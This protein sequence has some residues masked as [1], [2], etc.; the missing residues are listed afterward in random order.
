[1]ARF[2]PDGLSI[3]EKMIEK[4]LARTTRLYDREQEEPS[5][6]PLLGLYVRRWVNRLRC[7]ASAETSA[8][9]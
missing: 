8:I 4:F 3:A 7:S 5:G 6:S 9:L 2:S 1:M